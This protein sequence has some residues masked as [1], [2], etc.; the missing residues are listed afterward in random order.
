MAVALTTVISYVTGYNKDAFVDLS[1][2]RLDGLQ[3]KVAEFNSIQ[4]EIKSLGEER[5]AQGLKVDEELK[6]IKA[7]GHG[8]TSIELIKLKGDVEILSTRMEEAKNHAADIR[9]AIRKMKFEGVKEGEN[10][11]FYPKG[12]IPAGAPDRWR[13]MAHQDR[14]F[15]S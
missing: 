14:K 4:K 13:H 15:S 2:I 5:A 6:N 8:T 12:A 7:K 3:G 11:T 1:V 9:G 10:Y